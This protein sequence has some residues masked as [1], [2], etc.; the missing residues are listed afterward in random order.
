MATSRRNDHDPAKNC[1][2]VSPVTAEAPDLFRRFP[3]GE[4][5]LV[6]MMQASRMPAKEPKG[7]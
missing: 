4:S 3:V 2:S 1:A 5:G 7:K 6:K